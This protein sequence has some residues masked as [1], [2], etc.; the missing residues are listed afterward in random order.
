MTRRE[1]NELMLEYK[2]IEI[3]A[4]RNLKRDLD[5]E[6]ESLPEFDW[7]YIGAIDN[8]PMGTVIIVFEREKKGK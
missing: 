1:D 3:L 7:K 2:S 4:G 5:V 8:E 6:I